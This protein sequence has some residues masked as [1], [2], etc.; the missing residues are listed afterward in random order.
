MEHNLELEMIYFV[1]PVFLYANDDDRWHYS[2]L[3]F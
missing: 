1:V 2:S 3:V